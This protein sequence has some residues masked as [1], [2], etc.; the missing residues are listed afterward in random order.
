MSKDFKLE[1]SKA[2]YHWWHQRLSSI[3]IIIL[4]LAFVIRILLRIDI[5][6]FENNIKLLSYPINQAI[7]SSLIAVVFYHGTIGI[8][9]VLDDYIQNKILKKTLIYIIN[10]YSVVTVV[11][12]VTLLIN[13]NYTNYTL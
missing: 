3:V 1:G 5:N 4:L 9:S 7:V 12:S 11:S 8:Y 6:N 13:K 2:F 10:I